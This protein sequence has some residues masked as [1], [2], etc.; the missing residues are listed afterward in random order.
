MKT[1]ACECG[2]TFNSRQALGGHQSCCKAHL[3]EELYAEVIAKRQ[4][5][6]DKMRDVN[7]A[8]PSKSISRKTK[9]NPVKL[10][11]WIDEQH[12]CERCGKIM[13]EFYGVGRFCSLHC[14]NW[15]QGSE[16][17]RSQSKTRKEKPDWQVPS[18][19]PKVNIVP[20]FP[21]LPISNAPKL[22]DVNLNDYVDETENLIRNKLITVNQLPFYQ[23]DAREGVDFVYCPYCGVRVNV[24]GWHIKKHKKNREDVLL[25]F[26]NNILFIS[27]R[28]FFERSQQSKQIQKSLIAEGKHQ[29]W[30]S[31]N[32]KSYAEKFWKE[33][34][35][36][37]NIPYQEEYVL[38]K[39]DLGI[40]S[41]NN[42]FLD[43]LLP[44]NIDLE[45]DGKQHNYEDRKEHDKER[46]AILSQHGY[47]IY[48]IQWINPNTPSNKLKVQNQIKEFL[49]WYYNFINHS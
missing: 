24:L 48:R 27:K 33:V 29:G 3:G 38:K 22:S 26:G 9:N 4:V 8:K 23:K 45:I 31:R 30:K 19:E 21:K 28:A 43:F 1:Y 40:D 18:F 41:L 44:C 39:S 7:L 34:L 36:N 14:A 5:L 20:I 10:Q 47:T 15:R 42:F 16:T 6:V 49:D 46:D 13:T 37:N 12:Q 2:K 11:Q 17:F 25:E 32:T 35:D